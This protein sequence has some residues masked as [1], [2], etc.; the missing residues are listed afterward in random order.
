ML[1]CVLCTQLPRFLH[2]LHAV[3]LVVGAPCDLCG[4]ATHYLDVCVCV[5]GGFQCVLG[6]CLCLCWLCLT[7]LPMWQCSCTLGILAVF[8]C[9]CVAPSCHSAW[10]NVFSSFHCL[11][12]ISDLCTVT[13]HSALMRVFNAYI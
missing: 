9:P 11:A 10:F 7:C 13:P 8:L 3:F 12:N 5:L 4:G 6:E 2:F 1:C